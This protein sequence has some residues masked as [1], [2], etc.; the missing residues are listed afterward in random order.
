[1]WTW[2]SVCIR[3]RVYESV[4]CVVPNA[5]GWGQRVVCDG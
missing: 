2:M 5:R 3:V 1:M 4:V